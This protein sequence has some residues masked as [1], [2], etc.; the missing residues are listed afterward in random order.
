MGLGASETLVGVH[1]R[2]ATVLDLPGRRWG[3][4]LGPGNVGARNLTLG[5]SSFPA[6]SAP[7]GHVHREEEEMVYVVAGHGR[8]VADETVIELEPGMAV[9]IPRGVRH[10]T[11]AGPIEPLELVT[12]F[13]PPVVPGSY[14]ADRGANSDA[15]G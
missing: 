5:F 12:A 11:I 4:L 1:R 9:Y 13:S 2:D 10:T 6:G 3:L 7:A 8:L 15:V 14:E